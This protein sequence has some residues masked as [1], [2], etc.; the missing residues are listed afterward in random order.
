MKRDWWIWLL[1]LLVGFGIGL[2]YAWAVAPV[3]YV[4]TL[5]NTLRTDFKDQF[6]VAIAASYSATHNLD[7]AKARLALLGDADPVQALTAQAQRMLASGASFES[8]QQV[9]ALASDL[10]SGVASMLPTI[11]NTPTAIAPTV[12]AAMAVETAAT[13]TA[14]SETPTAMNESPTAV[15]S[16]STPQIFDTP[17]PRPTYTP[18]PTLGAPFKLVSQESICNP[19]LTDGL[20]QI[21]TLDG[22]RHQMPGVEIVITWNGGEEHI[23]TGLKPEIAN[24]YADYIMQTG[25]SYT[26]RVADSGSPVPNLTAPTCPGANNQT[27]LGGLHLTFQQP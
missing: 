21:T 16:T 23:F 13:S 11:T 26:V 12:S 9:A 22:A 6:R 8:I 27:Y 15:E 2:A 5:P 14:A 20:M 18:T 17:T 25:V 4:N 19:D 24:G 1:A 3:R 10:K 7:R